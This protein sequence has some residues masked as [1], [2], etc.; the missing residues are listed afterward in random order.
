[1][2]GTAATPTVVEKA[3]GGVVWRKIGYLRQRRWG[4]TAV[5]DSTVH[6]EERQG[7]VQSKEPAPWS[8]EEGLRPRL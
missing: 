5:R 1:M 7:C 2:V 4:A 3:N 8:L 6:P